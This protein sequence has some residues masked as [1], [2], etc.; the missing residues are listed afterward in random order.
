MKNGLLITCICLFTFH[1]YS[2]ID[3]DKSINLSGGPGN[4]K[5]SGIKDVSASQ[6]ALSVE[7]FQKGTFTYGGVSTGSGTAYTVSL[8]PS[9]SGYATGMVLY[10]KAHAANGAGP[11]TINVNAQGVKTIKKNNAQD[12]DANDISQDQVVCLVYD[13]TNFHL[14]SRSEAADQSATNELQTISGSGVNDITLSNGGGTISFAGTGATSVSR[15]GDTFTINSTDGDASTTNELQT[16]TAGPGANEV[17]L[18][19]AGGN[20]VINGTGLT[21]VSR[22]GTTFTVNSTGDGNSGGTVTG[23]GTTNKL[24]YWN[25][26]SSLSSNNNLSWDNANA[27]LGIGVA[28]PGFPLDISGTASQGIRYIKTGSSDARISVGDPTK[29]WSMAVGWQTAGD[30]S[31][32]EEG[33]SGNRLYIKQGGNVGIN[34]SNPQGALDVTGRASASSFKVS[35]TFG[36]LVNDAPWY[37]IGL[38]N[39]TLPGQGSTAVQLGGYYGL[40][41]A[42]SGA[43][44]MVINAGKVGIGTTNPNEAL[45]VGG[46]GNISIGYDYT[47]GNSI[48]KSFTNHHSAANVPSSLFIGINDGSVG[49][50]NIVNYRTGSFNSQYITFTTHHGGVSVAERMRITEDGNVGI[51]TTAPVYKLQVA[52]DVYASGQV[53]C[54]GGGICSDARYKKDI[55]PLNNALSDLMNLQGVKYN[56]RTDEFAEMHF[57]DKREI[58]FIAQEMEKVFPEIVNTT[59]TG[60]KSIDYGKLTAVL[61]ESI[62][63]QQAIIEKLQAENSSVKSDV[64]KLKA[65]MELIKEA[66]GVGKQVKK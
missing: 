34:N 64:D 20:I 31:F 32:I 39:T 22:S 8:T 21:S 4:A 53:Y 11:V 27:W 36:D 10:F 41:F 38:S 43:T 49:G 23:T 3:V 30:L 66:T 12:L 59:P 5:I 37:G 48:T 7:A 65:E 60:Y 63:D 54:F 26:A 18:S 44:R 42:E 61:V 45:S 47:G 15:S 62:K 56:W 51:G 16:L 14:Q 24:S 1:A 58:G 25:G 55:A 40:T 6:D 17:T 19:N 28:T 52:G 50:M 2:Q 46:S 33:I 13:G 35:S 9:I 29:T 57:P